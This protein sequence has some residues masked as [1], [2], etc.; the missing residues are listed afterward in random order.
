MKDALTRI[1]ILEA[2]LNAMTQAWLYLAANIEMQS[3][4]KMERMEVAL[5]K[6]RW[7]QHPAINGEARSTLRWL[8]DEM[9]NAR[10]VRQ[11]QA[12]DEGITH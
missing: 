3:D 11:A 9:A 6:R 1:Q 2:Q 12:R 7:P 5:R 10:A 4:I 8:C